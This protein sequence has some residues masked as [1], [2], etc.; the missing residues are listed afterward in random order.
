MARVRP[1]AQAWSADGGEVGVLLVHGFSGSPAA[2]RPLAQRLAAEGCAVELPRLPG[3]GTHWRDLAKVT[4]RDWAREAVAAQERLTARTRAHV[5]LGLSF[6]GCIALY[7]AANRP[8]HV[9]G[10]VLVNPAVRQRSPLLPLLPVLRRVL[11][12]IPGIVNDIAKPG[13]D[14][15]GYDKLPLRA[16]AEY[17]AFQGI[18]RDDLPRVTAPLLMFTSRRDHVVPAENSRLVLQ[19]VASRDR[20]H[21]WLERCHHVAT[22]DYEAPQIER[23]T[24]AFVHRAAA[25]D[26]RAS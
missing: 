13:A 11:P 16:V 9:A 17:T 23:E 19:R 7:L 4:W 24:V 25:A 22:L 2:L 3:H 8:E 20:T 10:L 26:A 6:G 14:E 1:G 12:F 21:R 18:V 15:V 5:V